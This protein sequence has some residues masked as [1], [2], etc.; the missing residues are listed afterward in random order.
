[1]RFLIKNSLVTPDGTEIIS[2]GRHD[3][4]THEDKNGKVYMVDGGNDYQ[5][6]SANGDEVDTSVWSDDDFNIVR[7]AMFANKL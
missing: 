3:Y 7:E 1:M 4:I 2:H 5:K 6:R